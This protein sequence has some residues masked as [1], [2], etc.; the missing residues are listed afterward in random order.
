MDTTVHTF[1][2]EKIRL[3]SF[4]GEL[5]LFLYKDIEDFILFD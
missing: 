1:R 4:T 2:Q 3:D 5:R